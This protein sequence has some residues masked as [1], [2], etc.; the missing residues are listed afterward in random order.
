MK[1]IAGCGMGAVAM[2]GM[3]G[4]WQL[5]A[6]LSPDAIGMIVGLLFG[7]LA[8]VP[9]TLLLLYGRQQDRPDASPRVIVVHGPA[10]LLAQPEAGEY[11]DVRPVRSR[12]LIVAK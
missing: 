12:R 8:G 11:V 6:Q 5:L 3:F 2:V 4:A 10:A 7:T 9:V 1:L